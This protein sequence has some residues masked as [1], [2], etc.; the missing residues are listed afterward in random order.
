MGLQDS[1]VTKNISLDQKLWRYMSLERLIQILETKKLYFTAINKYQLS[2]P[3]EG[4]LP[5]AFLSKMSE[6]ILSIKND[7]LKDIDNKEFYLF[8]K[9][10]DMPFELQQAQKEVFKEY[11][12]ETRNM[13]KLMEGIFFRILKSSVVSCWHQNESESEAMWKL[14]S[15]KGIAI[16]TTVQNLI[17]SIHD[18]RVSFSEVKYIDFNDQNIEFSDCIL[19]GGMNP[20]LKRL[21]FK[22]EQEARLYF[23]PD[24]DYS[25]DILEDRS[26]LIDIDVSRLISKIYISPY[27]DESC[28][29]EIRTSVKEFGVKD[30]DIIFSSLLTVDDNLM[31]LY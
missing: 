6:F 21:A 20:L 11:R 24:R 16:Q 17:D 28:A 10:S 7:I 31:K 3:F 29:N 14:Y 2:D 19:N 9:Y 26:E 22:H 25:S 13:H 8:K 27:L 23:T 18:Q 5:T 30:Q 1:L 12:N 15:Q 4:L